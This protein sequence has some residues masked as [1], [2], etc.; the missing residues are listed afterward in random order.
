MGLVRVV[1]SRAMTPGEH[2]YARLLCDGVMVV[3]GTAVTSGLSAIKP[4]TLRNNSHTQ[5]RARYN[6]FY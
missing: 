6:V 3:C 5:L 1:G 2:A 4:Q